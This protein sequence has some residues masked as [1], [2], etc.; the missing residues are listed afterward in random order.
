LDP[1]R[2]RRPEVFFNLGKENGVK[3]FVT[4]RAVRSKRA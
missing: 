2:Q 3:K 4:R 1:N